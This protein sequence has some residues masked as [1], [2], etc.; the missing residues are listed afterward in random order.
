[1]NLPR[2]IHPFP[3]RMAASIPWELLAEHDRR[4][5][6][7]V[8]DPMAGSG[9]VPIVA[10]VLGHHGIGFDLDPLAVLIARVWASN[11]DPVRVEAAA[12][13]A[14]SR[15]SE[16][17]RRSLPETYPRG[18]NAATRAYVRY[19]FDATARRQLAALAES[20]AM[21]ERAAL[22]RILWCAFSRLIIV[23]QAGA[24]RAMDVA[25]SRP[26]RV[27]NSAPIAPVDQFRRSIRH[28]VKV[29][30]FRDSSAPRAVVGPGDARSLMTVADQSIDYVI[31]SPPYLNAI[32]YLR[33]HRLS[34]VWMG[35][36]LE[37]LRDIRGRSIGTEAGASADADKT[38]TAPA[39]SAAVQDAALANREL[40]MLVRY[41]FDMRR[42]FDEIARVLRREGRA[43]VVV[44]NSMVRG[45][46]IRNSEGLKVVAASA[47]L[48]TVEEISRELPENRRYLPPPQA[49]EA[50]TGLAKRMREE[51]ILTFAHA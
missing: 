29:A 37:G 16:W 35:H 19:W 49:R 6:L 20:I 1:M 33:G 2:P 43:V 28:I 31:T 14:L 3:A 40:A 42:A 10:R 15:T 45:A 18:A 7:T 5:P 25:H 30:P 34:L 41:L 23:K 12:L 51:V 4:R 38:G 22:R 46:F 44:G 11:V 17:Q 39:V 47:G 9:T 50:G 27:Y 48:R 36:E 26:H 13:R 32:D 24:S 21:E 8:L